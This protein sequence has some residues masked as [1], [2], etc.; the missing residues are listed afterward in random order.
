M[1]SLPYDLVSD[2]PYADS[3]DPH[4]ELIMDSRECLR[5]V[6]KHLYSNEPLDRIALEDSLEEL[7]KLYSMRMPDN[8]LN[9]ERRKKSIRDYFSNLDM[10]SLY[11]TNKT[12]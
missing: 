1:S 7:C 9:I 2:D 6:L 8:F 10:Q 12:I 5:D 3:Y 4:S 11:I